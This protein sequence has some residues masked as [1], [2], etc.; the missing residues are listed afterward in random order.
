MVEGSIELILNRYL[1]LIRPKEGLKP[2]DIDSKDEIIVY[3]IDE[4]YDQYKILKIIN[5]G[6]HIEV[7]EYYYSYIGEIEVRKEF[8]GVK[9]SSVLQ[10][11]FPK[12]FN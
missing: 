1:E 3:T 2:T 4:D 9:P 6:S 11:F 12:V 7:S 8:H 5:Y 10:L